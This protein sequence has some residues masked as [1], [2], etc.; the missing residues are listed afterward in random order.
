MKPG[1]VSAVL[2]LAAGL[3]A[4]VAAGVTGLSTLC[5]LA[6]LGALAG[7]IATG[8]SAGVSLGGCGLAGSVAL[9]GLGP[10]SAPAAL[11]AAGA[12]IV[13]YDLGD[14]ALDVGRYPP[15]SRTVRGELAHAAG[16]SAFAGL[17]AGGGYLVFTLGASRGSPLAAAALLVGGVSLAAASRV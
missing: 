12:A 7:G 8:R 11:V 14:E 13:A 2:A 1:R 3:V 9:A 6:G 10:V 17:I 5:G 15:E 16:V 4:V